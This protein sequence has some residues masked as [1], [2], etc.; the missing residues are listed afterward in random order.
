MNCGEAA[1]KP[2][3]SARKTVRKGG[4]L[5]HYAVYP[6]FGAFT[7]RV[8][9]KKKRN[10][11][12]EICFFLRL[13]CKVNLFETQ[14]LTQLAAERGHEIVER[15]A[16]AVI[17]NTCTVTSVSDHKNIRAFHKLRRDNPDAVIAACGCFAQIDPERVKA[18]GEIDIIC[19]TTDRAQI[20]ERCE[21]AVQGRE[22][23]RLRARAMATSC[24]RP[25]FRR[26]VPVPSLK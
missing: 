2:L 16:D 7:E 3:W 22:Y 18:T 5:V 13:G 11:Q 24:F 21:A 14:A 10:V 20:I 9:G 12:H 25:A 15:G 17:V 26:D 4:P 1:K 19:G 8:S 6:L 23:R